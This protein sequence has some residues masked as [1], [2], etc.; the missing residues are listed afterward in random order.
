MPL[1]LTSLVPPISLRPAA[2]LTDEELMRFSEDNKPYKVERDKRGEITIM[3]PV[4]GIGSTHEFYVAAAL[5]NWNEIQT[6]GVAFGSNTG[7]NLPDG[8][9]LSPDAAWLALDRWN[10]LTTEQQTGY[11]PLCPDFIVEVRSRTDSR[12]LLEAK[13][14]LWLDNGARLAWLV[15]PIDNNVTLYCAGQAPQ[16][17]DQPEVVAAADPV[18]GFELRC[19]RLWS[20]R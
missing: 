10:A 13:M 11:P 3:T 1:N 8:S 16:T 19:N 20:P 14:Q 2:T 7:F 17:L 12:R 4:G 5:Y 9:C 6:K 18:F 15:D